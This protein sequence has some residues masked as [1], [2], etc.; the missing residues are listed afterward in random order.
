MELERLHFAL[1]ILFIL[2]SASILISVIFY[3]ANIKL[4]DMKID[5]NIAR[6]ITI[7]NDIIHLKEANSQLQLCMKQNLKERFAVI[8]TLCS[9]YFIGDNSEVQ[10]VIIYQA[11]EKEIAKFRNS[12]NIHRVEKLINESN[13]NIMIRIRARYPELSEETITLFILLCAGITPKAINVLTGMKLKTIYT[14]RARLKQR[15]KSDEWD[16]QDILL[17]FL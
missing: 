8:N 4:K 12:E 5:R 3:F 6:I 15:F 10:K 14:K 9:D 1:Y 17:S 2:F 13:D 16:G 11:V 7:S